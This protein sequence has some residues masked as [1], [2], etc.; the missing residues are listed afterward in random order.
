MP[1]TTLTG[2]TA[3]ILYLISVGLQGQAI[4]Q[5]SVRIT[6]QGGVLVF[7]LL[8]VLVHAVSA[9]T[10]ISRPD[11][12]HFG[13]FEVST[14]IFAFISLTAILSSMRN[15]LGQ[16]I[17]GV[18]PCAALIIVL[19][20]AIPSNYPAQQLGPGIVTHVLFSIFAYS[21]VT[22]AALHALFI[23]FQNYQL[24]HR[25]AAVLHRFPPLQDME[26]LLFGLL[27]AAQALLSAAI[28]TGFLF[29]RD[30]SV[31]GL[32]HKMFFS[33]LAWLVFAGLLWGRHQLG[34]RG[35]TAIKGTLAGFVMLLIG[36][37]GSKFVLEY[38]L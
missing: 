13:L 28:I 24:R 19:S 32:A 3:V 8:A 10:L 9:W 34:W 4:K 1:I 26:R 35:N 29:V 20:I 7:G 15:P 33:I 21:L 23:S 2:A 17:L 38:I 16:L 6:T 11:G 22:L 14:L 18:F 31:Q 5:R 25:A 36:F 27:W 37:Y 12:Y 30:W